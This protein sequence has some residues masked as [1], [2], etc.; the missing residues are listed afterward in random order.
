MNRNN[1]LVM[2]FLCFL[3]IVITSFLSISYNDDE[4]EIS[5]VNKVIPSHT[6]A[7]ILTAYDAFNQYLYDPVRKLYYRDS[8][9]SQAV[10]AIWT[11]AIYWDMAMNAYKKT[12]ALKYRQLMEDIYQG[13][14]VYYDHYNWNNGRVWFIYDDIMWWV[15]SLARAYELTEESKYLE[16]SESGFKRV[17]SGSLTVGDTGSYDPVNGGMFWQWN[18]N[19][20]SHR[21]PTDGKMS[22]INYPTVIAAMTLYNITHKSDYLDKAKEIY[23][24]ASKNLFNKQNGSVA[25]SKHG[26]NTPDWKTH[27]YNQAT[28]IGSAVMLY[29]ETKEQHYL[30]DAV[31]AADYTFN[32]MCGG[33]Q[34]LLFESGEEQGIY[35]AIFA[36]YIIRLIE[37][38]NKPEYF[39]W[40]RRTIDYGWYFRDPARNITSKNYLEQ[41]SITTPISCYDASGI[42]ALML[43]CSPDTVE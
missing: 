18:K 37:D 31:A 40:L 24:W 32:T 1:I 17:W 10:G 2:T 20:P 35:T 33:F 26:N 30:D 34:V 43:V 16:L 36:Q 21:Q 27:T 42:P 13:N 41:C 39:P 3:F 29:N 38:C 15:I 6:Q 9:R 8:D 12:H 28:C 5:V 23:G 11:Q 22:C 4:D 14:N 25:D 7:D 19:N